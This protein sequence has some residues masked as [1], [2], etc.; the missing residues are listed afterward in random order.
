MTT[1]IREILAR[2]RTCGCVADIL[3]CSACKSSQ[4]AA[5]VQ[6]LDDLSSSGMAQLLSSFAATGQRLL[7]TPSNGM[8]S[9]TEADA[10]EQLLLVSPCLYLHAHSMSASSPHPLHCDGLSSAHKP[11][12][13][14][15]IPSSPG[16]QNTCCETWASSHQENC[17]AVVLWA[18][19]E[20]WPRTPL[21]AHLMPRGM[22]ALSLADRW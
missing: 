10:M 12:T 14:D 4:H 8:D 22:Q 2:A 9:P 17:A 1:K 21:A 15:C 16:F 3:S 6:E 19:P 11:S 5:P 13:M 20:D 18:L 7:S